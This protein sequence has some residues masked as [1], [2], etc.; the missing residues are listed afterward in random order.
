MK[1]VASQAVSAP[2]ARLEELKFL[3]FL[4]VNSGPSDPG[5]FERNFGRFSVLSHALCVESGAG[6]RRA[7]GKKNVNLAMESL[8]TEHV[9]AKLRGYKNEMD[10][11]NIDFDRDVVT[12]SQLRERMAEWF[13]ESFGPVDLSDHCSVRPGLTQTR[14]FF[15]SLFSL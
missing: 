9:I 3:Q 11:Q 10:C 7:C 2:L 12:I 5:S 4:Y 8:M 15:L 1:T 13:F 14:R 6:E